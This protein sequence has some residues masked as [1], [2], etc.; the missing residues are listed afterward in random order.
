MWT[1]DGD[2]AIGGQD[3]FLD[4]CFRGLFFEIVARVIKCIPKKICVDLNIADRKG[5]VY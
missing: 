2:L 3:I 1:E 5:E 4:T